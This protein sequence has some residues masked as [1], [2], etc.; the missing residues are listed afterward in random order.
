MYTPTHSPSFSHTHSLPL[1]CCT[2]RLHR[3]ANSV[4][5]EREREGYDERNGVPGLGLCEGNGVSFLKMQGT[6]V[7]FD[8]N[9]GG[10]DKLG[11]ELI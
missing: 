11:L 7:E 8:L 10:E 6:C 3:A 5:G 4:E 9:M 1:S 2:L